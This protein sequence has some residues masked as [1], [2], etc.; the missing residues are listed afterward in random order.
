MN[1]FT[2][3]VQSITIV[4]QTLLLINLIRI[5]RSRRRSRR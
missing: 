5:R 1:A 2:I 3:T 4:L